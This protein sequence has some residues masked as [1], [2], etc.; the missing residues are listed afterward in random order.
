[1]K[2][3]L[4]FSLV[5]AAWQTACDVPASSTANTSQPLLDGE[6]SQSSGIVAVEVTRGADRQLCTG[7]LLL[8]N[9]VLTARHCLTL[10]QTGLDEARCE[11]AIL[12][13]ITE[14]TH[15]S[16][17]HAPD[18]D[19]A[20]AAERRDVIEA[21]LPSPTARL[22]GEDLAL[23]RLNGNLEG[24]T[25]ALTHTLPSPDSTFTAIGYGLSTGDYGRQRTTK[26]ARLRCLGTSCKDERL[27]ANEILVDSGACEGDSGGPAIDTAGNVF[28]IVSRSTADCASS[29][30]LTFL[31]HLDWLASVVREVQAETHAPLPEWAKTKDPNPPTD[32]PNGDDSPPEDEDAADHEPDNADVDDASALHVAG[33]CTTTAT[34]DRHTSTVFWTLVALV[35]TARR[36]VRQGLRRKR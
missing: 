11:A 31:Q 24:S 4:A 12:S 15:V 36:R 23:L 13:P 20:T 27:V 19:T 6:L 18:A 21:L 9:V 34:R 16:V 30:Y 28:A 2:R 17:I 32:V 35:A 25:F 5:L 3:W 10:P 8:P 33:G 22:C 1:M 14:D 26:E 29:A 7:V